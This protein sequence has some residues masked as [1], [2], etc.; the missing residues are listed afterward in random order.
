MTCQH[1]RCCRLGI[2]ILSLLWMLGGHPTGA[3]A[4]DGLRVT[5]YFISHTS[6]EPFYV[7]QKLDPTVVLHL[8]EIV[9]S[10]T[11]NKPSYIIGFPLPSLSFFSL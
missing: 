10:G 6:N 3:G 11:T 7:Q 2:L 8:R 5:D 9:L 4:T 1:S